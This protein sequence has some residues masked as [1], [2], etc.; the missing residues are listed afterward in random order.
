MSKLYDNYGEMSVTNYLW[1]HCNFM[2]LVEEIYKRT[3]MDF[4]LCLEK[5]TRNNKYKDMEIDEMAFSLDKYYGGIFIKWLGK[6]KK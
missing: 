5:L 6:F 4:L 3:D 1:C 2:T